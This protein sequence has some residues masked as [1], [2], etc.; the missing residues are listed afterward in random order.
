MVP[1]WTWPGSDDIGERAGECYTL[2]M[3][4]VLAN[5]WH[6]RRLWLVH[7]LLHADRSTQRDALAARP[8]G[9]PPPNPH[10]WCEL[11]LEDAVAALDPVLRMCVTVEEYGET[12]GAETLRRYRSDVA[13]E[14]ALRRGHHGP[15]DRR[16]I[17]AWELRQ[18]Q[19]R[20]NPEWSQA[21]TLERYFERSG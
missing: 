8:E 17:A 19:A 20:A 6:G 21:A 14:V 3:D 18:E 1:L 2:A 7:G 4:A 13:C 11:E 16:S 5:V 9:V 12:F 10:A 15:W